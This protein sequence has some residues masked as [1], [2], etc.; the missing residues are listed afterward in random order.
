MSIER[1]TT[2]FKHISIAVIYIVDQSATYAWLEFKTTS[3]SRNLALYFKL[4]VPFAFISVGSYFPI[5]MIWTRKREHII[6]LKAIVMHKVHK[7]RGIDVKKIMMIRFLY[8]SVL[9]WEK[10][11]F[12]RL[13]S[14]ENNLASCWWQR[15]IFFIVFVNLLCLNCAKNVIFLIKCMTVMLACN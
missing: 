13:L 4:T 8:W 14:Y 12:S 10:H 6:C 15:V 3:N 9:Y 11:K 1:P 7:E 5:L 2:I